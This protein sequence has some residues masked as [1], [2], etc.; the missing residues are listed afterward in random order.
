MTKNLKWIIIF[1]TPATLIF[2]FVYA[3]PIT[4]LFTTS[5]TDWSIGVAPKFIGIKN[6]IDLLTND[7]DFIKA[8][9][10]T[11]IWILLQSTIHVA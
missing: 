9:I 11:A 5:F 2:L 8:S 7:S 1:L 6:Y 10:N 3:V 4:I